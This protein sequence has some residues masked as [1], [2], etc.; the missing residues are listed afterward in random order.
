MGRFSVRSY[1]RSYVRTSPPLGQ[2]G[3]RPSQPGLRSSQ[4]GLGPSQPGLRP[5][6]PARP[7]GPEWGMDVGIDRQTDKKSPNFTG[8]CPLLGLLPCL[9]SRKS[10]SKIKIEQ[11]KGTTD[12]LMPLGNWLITKFALPHHQICPFSTQN[13]P[14]SI[15]IP[16]TSPTQYSPYSSNQVALFY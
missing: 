4:S 9:P 11:G 15:V 14:I 8:L 1:I 5:R 6:Q 10:Y 13:T 16:A 2:P 7:N 3:L 12:H